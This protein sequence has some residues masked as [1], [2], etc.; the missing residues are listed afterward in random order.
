MTKCTHFCS[1]TKI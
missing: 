1:K